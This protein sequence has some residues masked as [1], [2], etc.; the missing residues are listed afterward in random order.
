LTA[1]GEIEFVNNQTLEYLGK[2]LDELKNW[3]ASG[4]VYPDDLS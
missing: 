4:A 2:P 3:A 1:S